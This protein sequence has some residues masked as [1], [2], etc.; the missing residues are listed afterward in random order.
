[1]Y[2]IIVEKTGKTPVL[3]KIPITREFKQK[4]F[5][6]PQQRIRYQVKTNILSRIKLKLVD[7]DY[8]AIPLNGLDLS[9]AFL[10]SESV[11]KIIR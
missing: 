5:Y 4:I 3:A 1:M 7:K 6:E 11:N 2:D 8:K 10:A 9:A